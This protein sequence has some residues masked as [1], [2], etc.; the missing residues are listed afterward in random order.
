MG[1]T[2]RIRTT[3]L[4]GEKYIKVPIEQDFDFIK[5]LSLKI[6]QDDVYPQNC[7]DY[8][9]V[10]GRVTVNGGLG[11]P[12][13]KVSI[14]IPLSTDDESNPLISSIYPYKTTDDVNSEGVRYNLLP[15]NRQNK[16][17][18]PVGTFPS[19]R[20][21][22]DNNDILEI[23]EK[24]YKYTTSTNKAGDYMLC[25]VP[26]GQQ[27]IHIDVDMSDIGMLTQ[28]PYE[29]IRNGAATVNTVD[30]PSKF[31]SDTDLSTL[32]QIITENN[33]IDVLPF[34][35]DAEQCGIGINRYDINLAQRIEPVA[36]FIGSIF[37]DQDKNSVNKN[38][39][40]RTK[41]G[42]VCNTTT[43]E[44][45]I[46][47]IRKTLHDN[48]EY[49]TVDG[50]RNIDEDGTWIVPVPMNLDYII[51]DEF[52]EIIPCED[53]RKG[54]ATRARVR[55][56]IS[57]DNTGSEGRV[58]TRA[59]LLVPNNPPV[60]VEGD[61]TFGAETVD[62]NNNFV[63]LA[64]NNIYTVRNFIPRVQGK[65]IGNKPAE[66]RNFI[67]IKSVDDCD[68]YTEFPYNRADSKANP[69]FVILCLVMSLIIEIVGVINGFVIWAINKMI[70]GLNWLLKGLCEALGNFS[71]WLNGVGF[72]I[73]ALDFDWYPF[74]DVNL[75]ICTDGSC[76]SCC[77]C[78]VGYVGPITVKCGGNEYIPSYEYGC[79]LD[80]NDRDPTFCNGEYVIRCSDFITQNA[81][82]LYMACMQA[83][84]ADA[85]NVYKFDFYNDWIN[86]TL[87]AFQFK[88]KE[89][90]KG[91]IKYCAYDCN[92]WYGSGAGGVGYPN[93][94]DG[95]GD[96][97]ADNSC[98]RTYAFDTCSMN[99][100]MC[101]DPT[102]TELN[103]IMNFLS[104][105]TP[106]ENIISQ[107]YTFKEGLIKR[108]DSNLYYAS[109]NHSGFM[110][111]FATDITL[112]G[113]TT[114]WNL[115]GTPMIH[116][117]LLPTTYQIPPSAGNDG[118]LS[119][120]KEDGTSCLE[121][122]LFFLNCSGVKLFRRHCKDIRLICELGRGLDENNL[123]PYDY[124]A[125]TITHA[126]GVI[127]NKEIENEYVRRSLRHMNVIGLTNSS[128]ESDW[129]NAFRDFPLSHSQFGWG[130]GESSNVA[131]LYDNHPCEYSPTAHP[132][133]LPYNNSYYFYFGLHN[134]RTALDK[135]NTQYF[136]DC[137][138]VES[139]DFILTYTGTNV[140]TIGGSDGSIIIDVEGGTA[141]YLA[142]VTVNNQYVFGFNGASF[143]NSLTIPNLPAGT[144]TIKV[145]DSNGWVATI[146][147]VIIQPTSMTFE[148]TVINE[149]TFGGNE[150]SISVGYVVGGAAPYIATL[151]GPAPS[152]AS[153]AMTIG[154][155]GAGVTFSGLYAGTYTVTIVG[156]G[157]PASAPQTVTLTI[158]EPTVLTASTTQNVGL[159]CYQSNNGILTV[160]NIAGGT[161]PY[162]VATVGPYPATTT[163]NTY[164][165]VNLPAGI[166]SSTVTDSHGQIW[167]AVSTIIEP[168]Q[169]VWSVT[170][171]WYT[172]YNIA[173]NGGNDSITVNTNNTG[174]PPYIYIFDSVSGYSSTKSGLL[175]GSHS[176]QVVDA[177]GCLA[178]PS[179]QIVTLTQPP[180][181]AQTSVVVDA[182]C[183]GTLTGSITVTATGGVG[184]YG[185]SK[186]GGAYQN[187]IGSSPFVFGSLAAG[188][189]AIRVKDANG[190]F[191]G[192]V[193]VIV[194]EP[195]AITLVAV[196][197]TGGANMITGTVVG[198]TAPY[199][200]TATG[201][202][203]YSTT[204][205][206]IGSYFIGGITN[207]GTYTVTVADAN[208]CPCTPVT[209]VVVS[210]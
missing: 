125:N 181:L 21:V 11:V 97:V 46:E 78:L 183:N 137:D 153:S 84:L 45:M 192:P 81:T 13:A 65:I 12:N 40:A 152:T 136:T 2:I 47:M 50:G 196:G 110:K 176:V 42:K 90:R 92:D 205:P 178:T 5:I 61:Y 127:D 74:E 16:C 26:V 69:I 160:G 155:Q 107:P 164:N 103:P 1:E 115:S 147:V 154:Q 14:F 141:P 98:H 95:N 190:C 43:G 194:G 166:Y 189:Y 163:Y 193:T 22:L 70:Q 200:I 102:L 207:H 188:S 135:L 148:T 37:T 71:N 79:N 48:N 99:D 162:T 67:G 126:D 64:W 31:K 117:Y 168:S 179:T 82:N 133:G 187:G 80:G 201:P 140:T 191:N 34:W 18:V 25:G 105:K 10:V 83:E 197:S 157:P 52:G 146:T 203:T 167:N 9:V 54:L 177:H 3:P 35:G 96:G 130:D 7:A 28:R 204:I 4:S 109:T 138:F 44:G 113:S 104:T 91:K 49:F 116:Q 149:Y 114:E 198:G 8:G 77:G 101:D 15:K 118:G 20:E 144:Y 89:K 63:D 206:A 66:S 39:R 94:T 56:R 134:G 76:P 41:L 195:A 86:G 122:V 36:Y 172:G 145:I 23:F 57:M 180:I 59:K 171:N 100:S 27:T 202:S 158:T 132:L 106:C 182:T 72:S 88:Y 159:T 174:T 73:D 53:P 29:L 60:N 151:V 123:T 199:T 184:G 170:K 186:N 38:C 62:A 210:S 142:Y 129:H 93:F 32:P 108:F 6:S 112:L 119:W 128:P 156:I 120:Q 139:N 173:C 143:N 208:N 209:G 68:T 75:C 24:Y 150:G 19:K 111:L 87:Y 30:T 185:Y 175:A 161:P 55:F 124:F 33:S 51:T 131:N 17:H 121:P 58:R 169:L 85:L 165:A